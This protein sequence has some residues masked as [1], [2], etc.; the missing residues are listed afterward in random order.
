M[1]INSNFGTRLDR[2]FHNP[3]CASLLDRSVSIL[4]KEASTRFEDS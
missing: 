2:S 4:N 3:T 1:E